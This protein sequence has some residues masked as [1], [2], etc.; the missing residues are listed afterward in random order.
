VKRPTGKTLSDLSARLTSPELRRL[1]LLLVGWRQ[2]D[3]ANQQAADR[4]IQA[5]QREAHWRMLGIEANGNVLGLIGLD[6][7]TAEHG[8]IR[9]IVVHPASR[10]RGMGRSMIE[11]SCILLALRSVSAETDRDA[12]AFYARCGFVVTSL[13]EKYP[14]V[15]RFHCA[16]SRPSAS[17]SP[18]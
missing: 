1:L 2:S 4:T 16:R 17:P 5:Y 7:H 12:V 8:L 6:L 11:D 18:P 9:H 10:G 14:G 3:A 13:G 15:E